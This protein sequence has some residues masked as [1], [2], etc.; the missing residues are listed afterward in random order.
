ML[1]EPPVGSTTVVDVTNGTSSTGPGTTDDTGAS[2]GNV[3]PTCPVD[4]GCSNK[5]D[6]LFVI[7]N[8]GTMGEEQLNLAKNFGLLLQQLRSLSDED[9]DAVDVDVNIMVTTTDFDNPACQNP[10]PPPNYEAA[11]GAP[12]FTPCTERLA[13]FTS[14]DGQ[15]QL[16]Q[17]CTDVCDPTAPAAPTEHFIHFDRFGDNVEGGTVQDALSC[18]GPQ[19]IDGCGFESPLESM[20]QA[21]NPFA[22]WN[23]PDGCDDPKWAFV[24]RPFL[25]QD[26]VL[27]IVI[28]TDEAD[29]SVRDYSIMTD[30]T[31]MQTNPDTGQPAVSSGLCWNAGVVCSGLD[32]MTGAYDGCISAAK[33]PGGE[34]GVSDDEAVLHPLSRYRDLLEGLRSAGLVRD[35][36][37]LGVL[38]V[39]EVT[40]HA[41][42]PPHQPV[43]GGVSDLVYR[44]WRDPDVPS[45]G[46]ILPEEWVAGITA[47][48]KTFEFGVGPGCTGYDAAAGTYTGQAIPPVRIREVCESLD[49][50]DDPTTP[51]DETRVRCCI[52]S[53]CDDDF[54]A[55]IQCLAGLIQDV[56][57][58]VG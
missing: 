46:D 22:C 57:T 53:I 9:G 45:G 34:I 23:D 19:G 3:D 41:D 54:S 55:A 24:E 47:A 21:L 26:A 28:I 48:D 50:T 18:I 13:S 27:T 40:A 4:G 32:P 51:Q 15:T 37:M 43:A 31:F 12:V 52:E 49:V 36:V 17:A 7:D 6:L 25:R 11:E 20:L 30:P 8:S 29:C 16:P 14:R 44:Q 42:T 38:G 35:I 10:P 58:P 1:G 2:T 33:G 5:I 56:I 39:P